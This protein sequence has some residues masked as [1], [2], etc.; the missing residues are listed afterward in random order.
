MKTERLLVESVGVMEGE[1]RQSSEGLANEQTDLPTYCEVSV[2][3]M[4][5]VRNQEPEK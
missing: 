4:L 2:D 3:L 5:Q 1:S